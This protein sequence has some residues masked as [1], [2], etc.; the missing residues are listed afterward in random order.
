MNSS[1]TAKSSKVVTQKGVER[2]VEKFYREDPSLPPPHPDARIEVVCTNTET[3]EVTTFSV[4]LKEV[5][6][7]VRQP[8]C[9]SG[10]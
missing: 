8:A 5:Y 4:S 6:D 7:R 3:K 9:S 2:V 1:F 10:G